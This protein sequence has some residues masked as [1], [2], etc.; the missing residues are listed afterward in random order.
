MTDC[1]PKIPMPLTIPIK[2]ISYLH[3]KMYSYIYIHNCTL[4]HDGSI[5]LHQINEHNLI[6]YSPTYLA[7]VFLRICIC[8]CL[9]P[10]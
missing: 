5:P 4:F 9:L 2:Q 6:S 1:L 8:L 3:E 7:Y 10:S